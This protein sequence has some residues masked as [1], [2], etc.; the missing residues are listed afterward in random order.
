MDRLRGTLEVFCLYV[1]P[2]EVDGAFFCKGSQETDHF[3]EPRDAHRGL[4][5]RDAR[6]L[7]F[8]SQPARTEAEFKSAAGEEV[9]CA[10]FLGQNGR[11][12]II[13]TEDAATD[14]KSACGLGGHGHGWNR[15]DIL[16]GMIGRFECFP[17]SDE[18]IGQMKGGVAQIFHSAGAIAPLL[19]RIRSIRLD[20]KTERS[21]LAHWV[22]LAERVRALNK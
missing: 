14:T 3:L 20:G 12:S 10:G 6:R 1:V 7:V 19:G 8:G 5:E 13:D 11:L 17:R 4:V 18:V 21:R 16:D 15:G 22:I 9:E 2:L